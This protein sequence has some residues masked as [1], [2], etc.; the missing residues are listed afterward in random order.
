MVSS[1]G[2]RFIVAALLILTAACRSHS[3]ELDPY[4]AEKIVVKAPVNAGT[5]TAA[6]AA[7]QEA[8]AVAALSIAE[9]AWRSGDALTALAT[10]NHALIEGVPAELGPAFR[11][12][13][14]KARTAV[15]TTKIVRVRAVAERDAVADGSSVPVRIEFTNLSGATLRLPRSQKGSSPALVVLTLVREDYDLYGNERSSNATLNVPLESDLVLGPGATERI[16]VAVPADMMKLGHE[17]FSIIEMKGQ[18]RPVAIEVGESEFFDAI[19]LEPS[20]LHVFLKGY[21]PLAEDPLG[22]LKKSV[23]KRS[24]PHLFTCVE[25]LAPADRAEARTFLV[26]AKEKDPEMS[27]A[28]D[29]ALAR[30]A[31]AR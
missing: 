29:A 26:A 10:V 30:I 23:E 2:R 12:L 27:Q 11:D 14:A 28:I 20:R 5:T 19:P 8:R 24:P 6:D 3:R 15:V 9:S 1:Q 25:L 17:G 21:E 22:S 31:A 13:R 16:P 4:D 7:A 18:F